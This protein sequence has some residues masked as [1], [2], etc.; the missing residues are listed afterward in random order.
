[1]AET[2]TRLSPAAFQKHLLGTS[3]VDML[4]SKHRHWHI[5][6]PCDTLTH[7]RATTAEKLEGTRREVDAKFIFFSPLP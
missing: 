6:T 3:T 4:W 7:T 2:A 1:M 5:V